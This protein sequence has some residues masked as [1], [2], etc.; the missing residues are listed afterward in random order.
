MNQRADDLAAGLTGVTLVL[1][2]YFQFVI[3]TACIFYIVRARS[4]GHGGG[5]IAGFTCCGS[6][7]LLGTLETLLG[8]GH[9]GFPLVLTRKIFRTTARALLISGVLL[10]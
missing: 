4:R 3:G 7:L 6:G 1:L 10:G 5:V 2:A 9:Q 8:F